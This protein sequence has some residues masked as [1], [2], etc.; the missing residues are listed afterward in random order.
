MVVV[1]LWK[2][3]ELQNS[4]RQLISCSLPCSLL[5]SAVLFHWGYISALERKGLVIALVFRYLSLLSL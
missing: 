2:T 1:D 4:H 5:A 3:K